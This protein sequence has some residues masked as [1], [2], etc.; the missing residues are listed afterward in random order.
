MYNFT[1]RQVTSRNY[2]LDLYKIICM[3]F[4][5][6]FHFSDHGNVVVSCSQ[7]LSFNWCVLAIARIFGGI[8]NCA[9]MLISG[10]F[11]YQ[12]NFNTKG[13]F[14]LWL[15]VWFYS[16]TIGTFCYITGTEIFT[17]KSLVKMV[18]PFTFNQYWYFSTYIVIYLLFP[19]LN[20]WIDSLTKK[21]HQ[22]IIFLGISLFSI[23]PTL[24]NA[25]WIVGSNSIPIFFVLYFVGSYFNKY[26][27]S[28]S[29]QTIV[30]LSI[31]AL[32]IEIISLFF[33]RIVYYYT[34]QDIYFYLVWGTNKILPVITSTVLF[35][36]FKQIKIKHTKIITF[37]SSSV[38]GV[39]LFHI[40]RLNVLLFSNLFDNSATY[41]TNMLLPQMLISMCSIFAA[42]IL[43]DKIRIYIFEK[44]IMKLCSVPIYRLNNQIQKYYY[45]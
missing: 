41:E 28:I 4:V 3:F 23:L 2:G 24:T 19:Y 11:L 8:C 20:K 45:D 43:F 26:N 32:A 38:F 30:P 40:G 39:Y 1:S 17:V 13:L 34:G 35:L 6:A 15:E 37:I 42:G 16:V 25:L 10:Y 44:P 21:Q 22:G 29:K 18:F 36:A 12:K 27:I 31:I 33:M 14:K 5:I 7:D 9:F